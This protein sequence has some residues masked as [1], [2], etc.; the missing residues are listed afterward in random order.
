MPYKPCPAALAFWKAAA[1][2]LPRFISSKM[3]NKGVL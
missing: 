3:Q 2:A 1:C